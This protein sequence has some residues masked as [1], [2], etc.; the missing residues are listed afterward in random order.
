L[1]YNQDPNIRLSSF[2]VYQQTFTIKKTCTNK[3]ISPSLG[4]R[5]TL[6]LQIQKKHRLYKETS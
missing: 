1:I 5:K 3:T 2:N 6:F 4:L